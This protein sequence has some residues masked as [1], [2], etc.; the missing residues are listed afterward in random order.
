MVIAQKVSY[1]ITNF[2]LS[3]TFTGPHYVFNPLSVPSAKSFLRLGLGVLVVM[4][5]VIRDDD[6]KKSGI[7]QKIFSDRLYNKLTLIINQKVI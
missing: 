5:V 1:F 7:T 3:R 6:F 2:I 4:G